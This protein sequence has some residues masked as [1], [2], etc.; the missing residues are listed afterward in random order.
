MDLPVSTLDVLLERAESPVF[1]FA[2]VVRAQ[3]EGQVVIMDWQEGMGGDHHTTA[4]L[5]KRK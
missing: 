5:R 3:L 1:D 4:V 2:S